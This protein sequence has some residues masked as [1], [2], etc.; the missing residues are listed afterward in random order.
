MNIVCRIVNYDDINEY[1]YVCGAVT[2]KAVGDKCDLG[3]VRPF[4]ESKDGSL[5]E[6]QVKDTPHW[7]RFTCVSLGWGILSESPI[8]GP[9][10]SATLYRDTPTTTPSRS[11]HTRLL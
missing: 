3:K 5:M 6:M 1:D 2:V 4:T 7:S 11:T 9:F 8:S 10:P